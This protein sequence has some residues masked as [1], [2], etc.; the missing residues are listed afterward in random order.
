VGIKQRATRSLAI[1]QMKET[2]EK[3]YQVLIL[4]SELEKHSKSDLIEAFMRISISG[5]MRRL[6]TLQEGVLARRP[7][8]KFGDGLLDLQN[9]YEKMNPPTQPHD[10][11]GEL[12]CTY[13]T[14]LNDA[15]SFYWKLRSLR[16]NVVEKPVGKL[17]GSI[18]V[19]VPDDPAQWET[20]KQ[21]TA[22]MEAFIASRYR[23]TS[24]EEDEFNCLGSLL[25]WNT[26]GLSN[27]PIEK[28]MRALLEHQTKLPQG[29]LF[30]SGQ[31]MQDPGW[32]WAV[33][34][35]GNNAA[36]QLNAPINDFTPGVRDNRGFTVQYPSLVLPL[37]SCSQDF[38][39]LFVN[40]DN[41][42]EQP[43]W[44]RITR[45]GS[46]TVDRNTVASGDGELETPSKSA[47]ERRL[48]VIFYDSTGLM[49]SGVEMAAAVLS[50]PSYQNAVISNPPSAI[51]CDFEGLASVTVIGTCS[52]EVH[53]LLRQP[54]SKAVFIEQKAQFVHSKWLI[55]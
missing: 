34:R 37:A 45:L 5:W 27:I 41:M 32:R 4:D 53:S 38:T 1:A 31:R 28:R 25:G 19:I 21:C 7:F 14:P 18:Q 3:A 36:G 23:S 13:G 55:Q 35:F 52:E 51:L 6:W 50:I 20:S 33:T 49:T 24:R 17:I 43:M 30:V 39:E 2:Y 10:I 26:C 47:L 29:L 15:C 54:N 22:I 44:F 12:Q 16:A 46:Q 48:G 40:I 42:H 9:A 8:I 11:L